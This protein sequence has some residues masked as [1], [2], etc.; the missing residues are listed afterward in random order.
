MSG[1]I[2]PAG[3]FEGKRA[4]VTGA[5]SGIGMATARALHAEGADVVLADVAADRVEA[6]AAE[7]G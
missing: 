7:L 3:R 2:A 1:P 6:L 5:G 4:L